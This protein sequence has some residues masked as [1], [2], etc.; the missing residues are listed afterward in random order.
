M[1]KSFGLFLSAVIC[2]T[3]TGNVVRVKDGDTFVAEFDVWAKI[4]ITETVRVAGIDTPEMRK[5]PRVIETKKQRADRLNRANAAKR[6]TEKWLARGKFSFYTCGVY[7]FGRIVGVP[8]RNGRS[9]AI[10]LK[11][12]GHEKRP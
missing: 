5:P 12:A 7:T 10:E 2:W 4:L 8:S 11:E 9:L 6:F 3:V 1:K